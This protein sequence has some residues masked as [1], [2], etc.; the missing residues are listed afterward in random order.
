MI[1]PMKSPFAMNKH[2]NAFPGIRSG[3]RHIPSLPQRQRGVGLIEV[4]VAVLV[5]AIGLLGIAALQATALRNSQSSLERSQ[6][7]VNSY[8]IYDA[9][10]ANRKA[11]FD[12]EY[13]IQMTCEA[14]TGTSLAQADIARWMGFMEAAFGGDES[15]VCGQISCDGDGKCEVTVQWNDERGSEGEEKFKITTKTQL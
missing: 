15:E 5:L 11:V 1:E 10:R 14:P 4:L 2:V 8:T 12:G 13:N 9:M 7:V 6:A 3:T